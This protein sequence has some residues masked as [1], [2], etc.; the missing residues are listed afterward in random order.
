MQ[1]M[2]ALSHLAA[3]LQLVR[4]AALVG[5]TGR[6]HI[7]LGRLHGCEGKPHIC[8]PVPQLIRQMTVSAELH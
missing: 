7:L 2:I 4:V 1:M 8:E 5:A 3:V 6:I